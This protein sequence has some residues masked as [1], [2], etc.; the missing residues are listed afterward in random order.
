MIQKKGGIKV[1]QAMLRD[2]LRVLA[3]EQ[4]LDEIRFISAAKFFPED[5]FRGRQPEDALP[6]AQTIVVGAIYLGNF[7]LSQWREP[8]ALRTSRL[9]L[10]GFYFDVVEPLA[11]L[12]AFLRQQGYRAEI[13]DGFAE[14]NSIPL[15]QAALRAGLG[16][17][18]KNTL[19]LSEDYGSW[20][21]FGGIITDAPM[22]E[23]YPPAVNRCGSCDR[24]QKACPLG[25]LATP[26]IIDRSH[27]LSEVMESEAAEV[28]LVRKSPGYFLECDICQEVCPWN[29]RHLEQPLAT[30]RGDEFARERP[31]LEALFAEAR[32]GEIDEA[33]YNQQILPH[34][35][36]VNLPFTLFRRNLG[37]AKQ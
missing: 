2:R 3:K 19:I 5:V 33:T 26:G 37:A 17:Q 4:A 9:V 24:C 16:W 18:G 23:T 34:L 8:G 11:P 27:C 29:R 30:P 15:K 7:F 14:A 21:T 28:A 13:C 22:A 12:A 10:S 1:E 31:A 35:S 6:G 36:G 20:L 32:L 25:G